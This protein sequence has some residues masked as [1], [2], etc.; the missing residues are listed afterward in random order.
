MPYIRVAVKRK[1]W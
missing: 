1:C